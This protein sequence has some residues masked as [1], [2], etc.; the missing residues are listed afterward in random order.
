[1]AEVQKFLKTFSNLQ[2][3][4]LDE[5]DNAKPGGTLFNK[6]KKAMMSLPSNQRNTCLAFHGTAENNI[7]SIC[8]TGYDPKRRSGQAMGPGEYFATSPSTPMS[9][10]RGGK[11]M[12][13][14]ELL[15]G[16]SGTHHTKHGDVVVMTNPEHD[17]PRFIVTFR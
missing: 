3:V 4:K 2:V 10:C 1:M 13:L 16:Q 9:Y 12:L 15:L 8:S 5:N 11:K 14:N 7:Q 17:L 6:F